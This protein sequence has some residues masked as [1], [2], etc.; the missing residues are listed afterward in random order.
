M[1]LE[2]ACKA[3]TAS[4]TRTQGLHIVTAVE[5][6]RQPSLSGQTKLIE[7]IIGRVDTSSL[8]IQ[9]IRCRQYIHGRCPRL[10][11]HRPVGAQPEALHLHHH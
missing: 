4:G 8:C 1:P 2:L 7:Y 11:E 9:H 5:P 3:T 10:S 6:V